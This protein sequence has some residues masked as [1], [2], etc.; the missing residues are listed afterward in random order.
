MRERPSP[1]ARQGLRAF[2][3]HLSPFSDRIAIARV[4][5][6]ARDLLPN[7][8][9]PLPKSKS[10]QA[11]TEYFD[12]HSVAEIWDQLPEAKPAKLSPALASKLRE[13]RERTKSPISIR[14]E[15]EQIEAAKCVAVGGVPN[16]TENVDRRRDFDGM[17]NEFKA[18]CQSNY[19]HV[20]M[21]GERPR[22][23]A[24]RAADSFISLIIPITF[25]RSRMNVCRGFCKS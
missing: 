24:I 20:R 6:G 21:S 2:F 8:K 25:G 14:L 1:L 9:A 13:R 4:L 7:A 15:P 11:V 12:N 10:D 3:D 19:F 22:E 5:H 16:A 18:T 17:K 23:A